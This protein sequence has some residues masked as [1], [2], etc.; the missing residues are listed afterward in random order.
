M[1]R[2]RDVQETVQRQAERRVVVI[3]PRQAGGGD[4]V[5]VIGPLMRDDLALFRFAHRMPVIPGDA[6]RAV[7]AFRPR[8]GEPYLRH[9]HRRDFQQLLRQVDHRAVALVIGQMIIG[10]LRHLRGGGI[11]QPL[12]S[13]TQRQAPQP[14]HALDI[15]VAMVVG[16]PD[17]VAFLDHQRA[18]FE[19]RLQ[20][21]QR[22]DDGGRVAGFR[23]IGMGGCVGHDFLFRS[24]ARYF[25]PLR[26]QCK[27]RFPPDPAHRMR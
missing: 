16:D 11:H 3:H 4:G 2:R 9:R 14:R 13:V 8:I 22:V 20:V 10:Q 1:M 26:G 19:M 17:T 12:L 18:F 23:G 25:A 27:R 24:R 15:P 21:G 7:I 6:R 5:A